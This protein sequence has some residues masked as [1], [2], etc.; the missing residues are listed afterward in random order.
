[1]LREASYSLVKELEFLVD[2]EMGQKLFNSHIGISDLTPDFN[3]RIKYLLAECVQRNMARDGN[4][5][6][7]RILECFMRYDL[8]LARKYLSA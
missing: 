1:M 3:Y 5:F 7:G 8:K 6:K 4:R 2:I